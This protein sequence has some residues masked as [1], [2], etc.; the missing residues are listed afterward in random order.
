[1][2]GQVRGVRITDRTIAPLDL[3]IEQIEFAYQALSDFYR[4]L[5]STERRFEYVLK[6]GEMV[7]FDNHQVLH[8]RHAFDPEAG[9]R[10]L[11]Q[12]SVDREEFHNRL[13]QLADQLGREDIRH[14]EA[15]AGCLSYG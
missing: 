7:I 3:P 4:V 1:M 10:W 8:A 13:R 12:L 6:P 2:S 11:Q 14:W 15:D 9:E 5:T